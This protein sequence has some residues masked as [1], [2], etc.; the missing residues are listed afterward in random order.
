MNKLS[1]STSGNYVQHVAEVV[2]KA[3][4]F[5]CKILRTFRSSFARL[6]MLA[7]STYVMPILM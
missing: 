5:S 7:F 1:K 6:L 2:T 3:S 4:R